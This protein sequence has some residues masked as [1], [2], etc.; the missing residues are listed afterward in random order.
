MKA[1]FNHIARDS[2]RS[3]ALMF[4]GML[5]LGIGIGGSL[6]MAGVF[7]SHDDP[8]TIHACVSV[9]SGTPR[10]VSDPAYCNRWEMLVEWQRGAELESRLSALEARVPNC[11]QAVGNDAVFSGCNVYVQN[12]EDATDTANGSGNL[13]VGYNESGEDDE[14]RTGSHNLVIGPE[15]SY[16]SYGGLIAGRDN[17]VSGEYAS[18]TAGTLNTAS[19]PGSSVSGG[20]GNIASGERS[21]VSGGDD[22]NAAGLWSSISGGESHVASGTASSVGGGIQNEASGAY[23]TVSGGS[24]VIA[25]GPDDWRAGSL[26]EDF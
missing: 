4:V 17:T 23:S 14:D 11:L 7:A 19:G 26:F 15:H 25:D 6:G 16:S 10:I 13:I 8:D 24:G 20:E 3:I 18:V 9:T 12:G 21:S 5:A 22:N 1:V 2:G